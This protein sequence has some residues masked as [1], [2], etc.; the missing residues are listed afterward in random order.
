MTNI[1]IL[2]LI[3]G[4][5]FI[6]FLMSIISNAIFEG[7]SSFM[8]I[9]AKMLEEWIRAA[10]P[11]LADTILDHTLVNGLSKPGRSNAYLTGKNFSLAIIDI[12]AQKYQEVPKDLARLS[13]LIDKLKADNSDLIPDDLMRSM[14]LFIVE[15]QQA[16][17]KVGQLKTE[18][19]LYN[20]QVEKW[21]DSM[22]E[23]LTGSYKRYAAKITFII[24]FAASFA[25]NIDSINIA[26]YLYANKDAREKLAVAAYAAPEDSAYIAKVNQMRTKTTI[27]T[28]TNTNDSIHTIVKTVKHEINT[29]DSTQKY[30]VSFFPIGWNTKAEFN[31]FKAQHSV[32]SKQKTATC[33]GWLWIL[34]YISKFFGL[35][36]TVLAIS[37]GAPFWFDMLN[38]VANLRSSLKPESVNA[39]SQNK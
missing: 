17:A 13:A 16:S 19:E 31:V 5:I 23:R 25:M 28:T 10:L 3:A 15:A 30:L 11:K 4:M 1:P 14:Q 12:I 33:D 32:K 7:L 37:M 9:R 6:Y 36:I 18:F 26:E 38:K 21:F 29:I 39:K 24:A 34:F 20:D 8:K 2:D 27:D 22:M 35:M